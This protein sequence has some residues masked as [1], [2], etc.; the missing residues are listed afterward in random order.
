MADK[1]DEWAMGRAWGWIRWIR[2]QWL[3]LLFLGGA[4]VG[5]SD[6]VEAW[7][8][9]PADLAALKR[10]VTEVAAGIS[11]IEAADAGDTAS[12]ASPG[13]AVAFPGDRHRIEDGAA[14][15]WTVVR[16]RPARALRS[17]CRPG[18]VDVWIVDAGGRWF[19]ADTRLGR[20]PR[21]TGDTDLAFGV[22]IPG[23]AAPGRA[24][25]RVQLTHTCGGHLQVQVAPWLPFRVR[26]ASAP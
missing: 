25:A 23:D 18:R 8:T 22:R 9:V 19:T 10:A 4:L 3:M 16:L 2:E 6:A 24:E 13:A 17:D 12:A 14:G 5:I 21:L 15:A 20:V 26:G 7:R 11:R 1:A